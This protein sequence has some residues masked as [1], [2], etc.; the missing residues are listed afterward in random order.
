MLYSCTNMATVVVK[1]LT[2]TAAAAAMEAA[3]VS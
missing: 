3:V 1:G 2:A